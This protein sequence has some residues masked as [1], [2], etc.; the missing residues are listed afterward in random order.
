MACLRAS[1]LTFTRPVFGTAGQSAH[2]VDGPVLRDPA[3]DGEECP[4]KMS[5]F[6]VIC[7][8]IYCILAICYHS[9]K[10]RLFFLQTACGSHQCENDAALPPCEAK[11]HCMQ[12]QT[13]VLRGCEHGALGL[14]KRGN[15]AAGRLKMVKEWILII[16]V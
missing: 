4:C 5:C 16:T 8:Y 11:T 15:R 7:D 14:H 10:C 12:R 13:P 3:T 6:V 9:L 1:S 2:H